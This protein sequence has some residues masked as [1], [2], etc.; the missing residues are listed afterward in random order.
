M[1]KRPTKK[2]FERVRAVLQRET[3]AG[4]SIDEAIERAVAEEPEAPGRIIGSKER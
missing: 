2:D 4:R 3:K 1:S